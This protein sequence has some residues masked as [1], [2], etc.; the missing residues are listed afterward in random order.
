M[1]PLPFMLG[2]PPPIA[3]PPLQVL[4]DK[5][6]NVVYF[7]ERECSIQR[8]NQKVGGTGGDLGQGASQAAPSDVRSAALW[9]SI[10]AT[11]PS[12]PL[13]ICPARV[14]KLPRPL[15]TR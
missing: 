1:R 7:P 2:S 4:G 5:H 10:C 15:P 11:R 9:H 3:H 13:V 8:R 12:Q 6:G 14:P